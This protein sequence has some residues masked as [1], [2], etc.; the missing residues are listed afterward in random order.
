M[1][2]ASLREIKASALTPRIAAFA[3]ALS[4]QCDKFLKPALRLVWLRQ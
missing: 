3:A 2:G 4:K 1:S